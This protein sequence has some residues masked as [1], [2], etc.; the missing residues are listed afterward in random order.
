M[1]RLLAQ[2]LIPTRAASVLTLLALLAAAPTAKADTIGY[3]L[4]VPNPAISLFVGPYADVL[5]DR[6]SLTSALITFT[7][8]S[9]GSNTYLFG[10][11]GSAGVNVNAASWLVGSISGSNA[12]TGFTPGAF[13]DAGSGNQDG[14]GSFN[15]KIDTFD[16]Y[17]H[18]ANILSFILTN[19]SGTWASAADVLTPNG[20]GNVAS[21]HIFVGDCADASLCD[22]GTGALATG[23]ATV[24]EPGTGLLLGMGLTA[25]AVRGRRASS[26]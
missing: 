16:G 20:S 8:L 5:V 17:T 13:S 18:S 19:T 11:G 1:M 24:P 12:G 22:A 2:K 21:A 3:Q 10:D 23:Y 15:Q 9:N 6:T 26:R 4:T 14:F 25:L 7:S